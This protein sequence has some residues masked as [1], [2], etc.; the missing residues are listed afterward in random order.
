MDAL[1][2]DRHAGQHRAH[3]AERL[4]AAKGIPGTRARCF[5]QGYFRG[6]RAA[7]RL[8]EHDE[9]LQLCQRGMSLHSDAAELQQLSMEAEKKTKVCSFLLLAVRAL[10]ELC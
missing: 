10:H 1:W 6:A 2:A 9:A 3:K 5:I 4:Y 7:L 8:G